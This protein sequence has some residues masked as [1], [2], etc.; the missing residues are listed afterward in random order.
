MSLLKAK[1]T[2]SE[3]RLQ[4]I[5]AQ[6]GLASRRKAEE[7]IRAGRVSV[8]GKTVTQL[9]LKIAPGAHRIEVDGRP[10]PSHESKV[11]Y[12]FNKPKGVLSTLMDP[13]GRPTVKDFLSQAQI[14]ERL[15]PVGRL[16]WDAEG[17]ILLTNDG[18]LAQTLQHPRFQIPKTYR[19][20]VQGIPSEEALHRLEAGIKLPSGKRSSAG[21]EKIK[22]GTD[23]SWLFITI[24]EGEKH[25]VKNM[26]AAIGH[27][28]MAIKRVAFG[29][30]TLGR[31]V[32]GELRPLSE[33]EIRTLPRFG[34]T[35]LQVGAVSLKQRM[36]K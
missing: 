36:D 34:V 20:K 11:Y 1:P 7:W 5:L 23:R 25:Q 35:N 12:L 13:Q 32:P 19:V 4:R 3:Q 16:D 26:L 30:L 27:P 2:E 33:E 6:A 8:D 14:R 24:R 28:V 17:L 21:W 22:T 10:I 18:E 9:G 15:F 31:L 29:P